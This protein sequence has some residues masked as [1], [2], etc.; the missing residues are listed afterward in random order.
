MNLFVFSF[1]IL[2][3]F[4]TRYLI[5]IDDIWSISAWE[6]LK[7]VM[8]ENGFGS[9]IITTTRTF[10]IATSCC[11]SFS[12]NIF[13]IE[14]LNDDDSIKLFCRRI[15]H[16]D[17]CPTHLEELAKAI[18]RKCGGLP[19]AI[20]HISS[21]LAAKSHSKDEWELV[22]NSLGSALENNHSLQGMKNILLLSF[23][24]LP[25]HLKTCLLHQSIHPEDYIVP[26]R[27]LK[28]RWISEGFI[29]EERGKRLDQVAQ[30]YINDLVNRSMILTVDIGY[31]GQVQSFQVHDLVLNIIQNMSD[32]HNFVTVVDG[33]QSS[34]LPK[35]IRRLS[36]HFNGSED[37]LMG[38]SMERQNYVRSLTIFGHTKIVP[39]FSHLHDLRVLDLGGCELLENHHIKCVCSI[40][41]LRFLVL[42]SKFISKLPEEIG[43][44]QNLQM[45]DVTLCSLQTL[46]E[47]ISKLNKLVSMFVSGVK[48]SAKIGNMR[49]LE[50]LSCIRISSNCIE[51]VEELGLLRKLRCLAITVEDASDMDDHGRRYREALLSTIYQLG[52]YNLESLSLYYRGHED[53]IL[54]SSMGSCYAP[55]RLRKLVIGKPLSRIPTWMN[56][57]I[58]LTHIE[59]NISRMD[60]N[61]IIILKGIAS[62]AFLR[63]VF[64]GTVDT[65]RIVFDD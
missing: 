30:S 42:H 52:R 9:R 5:V 34:S 48:I 23:Y 15:F 17:S 3:I 14:S 56:M 29:S 25:P 31:D 27:R 1:S 10:D 22:L 53:F 44:L 54:D 59:L 4:P 16:T 49:S 18:L 47:A 35:K 62:L 6:I 45:M 65:M 50:E 55:E 38:S 41:Q 8:P 57:L 11:S 64:T 21:L 33:Q 51:F 46:P 39:S 19:L 63:L 58:N 24:D 28:M 60:V 36:L 2:Y 13:R 32:E 20:L 40:L 37:V 43:N 26:T 61:D 7:C 12:G